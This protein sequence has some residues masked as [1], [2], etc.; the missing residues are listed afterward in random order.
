M[1]SSPARCPFTGDAKDLISPGLFRD[2]DPHAVW[3]YQRHM[4]PVSWQQ[5]T[6]GLG[7]W[8]VTTYTDVE[9]VLRD[10]ESFTSE[11]GTMLVLLGRSDPASGR[12]MAVTDPPRHGELHD[13]VQRALH[14]KAMEPR[15]EQMREAIVELLTPLGEDDKYD[16]AEH[17]AQVPMAM[18]GSLMDLPRDDWPHLTRLSL[19]SV[20]PLDPILEETGDAE[21]VLNNVHR[22]LFAYFADLAEHRRRHPG[23]DLVSLLLG[24][25][26]DGRPLTMGEISSNCYG[27]LVGANAT[28]GQVVLNTLADLMGTAV[29]AEWSEDPGLLATGVEEALR[30]GTPTSHFM[31]YART[32]VE[33][34]GKQIRAGDAVVAWPGSA[35]RDEEV[36][37]AADTFDV[38][39]RP[40]RHLAFGSGPHYCVGHSVARIALRLLFAELFSRYSD[41]EPTGPG[42]RMYS[43]IIH[44]W[45]RMPVTAKVRTRRLPPA[46]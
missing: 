29:L 6:D 36:F 18:I 33:L 31:R 13:P 38:R 45:T 17:M 7:F 19:A 41:F 43:N 44:G 20:A 2:G 24:M 14:V 26:R 1:K 34:R 12:Q 15:R 11:Q 4:D 39:R 3:R 21:S 35:N 46:Y 32:D 40:N 37:T 42:V 5:V 28:T 10:H 23:D 27:L 22:E 9:R 25:E 30:W 8:S 16:L